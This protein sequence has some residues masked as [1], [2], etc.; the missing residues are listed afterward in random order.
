MLFE[1]DGKTGKASF[2][3][4]P[5]RVTKGGQ[6]TVVMTVTDACGNRS[7]STDSFIW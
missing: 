1:L 5:D 4:D 3:L 6:H 7:V 2:R